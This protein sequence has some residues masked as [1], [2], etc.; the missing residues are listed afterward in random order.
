MASMIKKHEQ[1]Q[2]N[3]IKLWDGIIEYDKSVPDAKTQAVKAAMEAGLVEFDQH[4]KALLNILHDAHDHGPKSEPFD[5]DQSWS[6]LTGL[7][8]INYWQARVKQERVPVADRVARLRE[9]AKAL[10]KARNMTDRAMQDDVGNDLFAAWWEGTN[11]TVVRDDDGSVVL[12]RTIN[13]MFQEAVTGLAALE[14]AAVRAASEAH[15]ERARRSGPRK[16]TML[17]DY[18]GTLA[19]VYRESTGAK[20]GAGHGPFVRFVCAFLAAIRTNISEDYAV[21]LVQNARSW[22]RTRG[23]WTSSP[24][25]D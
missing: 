5:E 4:K 10:G 3:K 22:W 8:R 12:V 13:E 2:S 18:V 24:F 21:E 7:A 14:T 15:E 23:N 17:L 1:K 9:L 16:R 20:P 19:A 25:D 6:H 11:E